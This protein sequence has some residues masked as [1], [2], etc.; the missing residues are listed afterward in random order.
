[1]DVALLFLSLI[2]QT[3]AQTADIINRA[4]E[5]GYETGTRGAVANRRVADELYRQA[6]EN[7]R[8]AWQSTPPNVSLLAK[9]LQQ[10]KDAKAADDQAKEMA[11]AALHASNTGSKS[12]DFINSRYGMISESKLKELSSTNSP[13]QSRVEQTLGGYG[14]KLSADKMI[15]Q[16]PFGKFSVN[17][18]DSTLLRTASSIAKSLGYNPGD[19]AKGQKDAI[20]AR[21]AVA[22]KTVAE[23]D[24]ELASR[25]KGQ[26]AESSRQLAGVP[27]ASSEAD[28]KNDKVIGSQA[29]AQPVKN[30]DGSTTTPVTKTLTEAEQEVLRKRKAMGRELGLNEIDALGRSTQDIFQMIHSRYQRLDSEGVFYTK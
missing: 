16:T 20:A 30:F 27:S 24:K 22:Q 21:D 8:K 4:G 13:Y 1:M 9:A 14:L 25:G 7:E 5:L 10:S 17:A 2:L 15:L 12:G 6:L 3:S 26:D 29:G 19:V 23:V 18:E 28:G 11:R